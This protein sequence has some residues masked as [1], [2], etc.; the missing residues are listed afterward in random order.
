M[1]LVGFE[2]TTPVFEQAMKVHALDRSATGIG[3]VTSQQT[4]I[5]GFIWLRM[6]TS[7]GSL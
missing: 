1:P 6:G 7:G 3:T 5:L 4:I 2:T